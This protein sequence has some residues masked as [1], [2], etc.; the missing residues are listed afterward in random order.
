MSPRHARSP[1][2]PLQRSNILAH[3]WTC[4]DVWP[5]HVCRDFIVDWAAVLERR[6]QVHGTREAERVRVHGAG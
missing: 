2:P 4:E 5:P 3:I 1:P 6:V